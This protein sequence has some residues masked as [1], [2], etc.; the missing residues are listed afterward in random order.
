MTIVP[1]LEGGS[2]RMVADL[3]A[4][5]FCCSRIVNPLAKE[6]LPE[7]GVQRLQLLPFPII[8]LGGMLVLQCTEKPLQY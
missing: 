7:E 4:D 6:N 2:R 8:I 3:L 1:D 5:Q